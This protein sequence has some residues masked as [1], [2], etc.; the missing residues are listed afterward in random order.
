V[1]VE[2]APIRLW[3]HDLAGSPHAAVG[4]L[5]GFHGLDPLEVLGASWD[6]RHAPRDGWP[7]SALPS[8]A[9]E[10]SLSPRWRREAD[11]GAAWRQ[12]R[13]QLA[14]GTPVVLA[15]DELHLPFRPAYRHAH[16]R[17]LLVA[18][19]FDDEAELVFVADPTPPRFQGSLALSALAAAR[20]AEDGQ[21]WLELELRGPRRAFGPT[22]VREALERNVRRFR[23]SSGG[24]LDRERRFLGGTVDRL[25]RGEP[26]AVEA[27]ET[28]DAALATTGLHS[29]YL[30]LA[31]RRLHEPALAEVGRA[32]ERVAH[33]W[34][35]LRVALVEA[36]AEA[37]A[38][39]L[40]RRVAALLRDHELAL[41][42]LERAAA[43]L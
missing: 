7:E 40:R 12:V 43:R 15:V 30:A 19:G 35:A 27:L 25:V 8:G 5:L 11:P 17:R 36:G 3:R 21:P 31:G 41:G 9:D 6:F 20:E 16:A 39:P 32:V 29:D 13:G 37:E 34:T 10:R 18:Y 22:A 42:R 26:L 14:G 2:L 23:P 33:H 28:V 4:T 38:P 1:K 24:A